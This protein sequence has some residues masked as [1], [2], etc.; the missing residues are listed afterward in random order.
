MRDFQRVIGDEAAAQLSDRRVEPKAVFACVGGGSN[1]IGTFH[2]FRDDDV[3][4][5]GVEAGGREAELGHGVDNAAL[6]RFKAIADVRQGT[7]HDDIHGVIEI[8]TF[9][10]LRQWKFFYAFEF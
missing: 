9:C 6:H 2:A 3:R 10:E 4:L 1:A 7:V 5:I 8:R